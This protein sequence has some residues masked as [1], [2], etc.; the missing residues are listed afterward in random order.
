MAMLKVILY[1]HTFIFKGKQV[2]SDWLY[3]APPG[4]KMNVSQSGWIDQHVFDDQ[5][6]PNVMTNEEKKVLICDN[7]SSH[8]S[9]ST[10]RLCE[11]NKISI[12]LVPNSTHLLQPLDVAYFASLKTFWRQTL[13]DWRQTKDGKRCVALPK[14]VFSQLLKKTLALCENTSRQNLQKGFEST[15]MFPI[16]RET[17]L[18]KLPNYAKDVAEVSKQ[19]GVEFTR[20]LENIR[21]ADLNILPKPRKFLLPVIPGKSVS[22]EE[23]ANYYSNRQS[24]EASLRGK[25]RTRGGVRRNGRGGIKTLGRKTVTEIDNDVQ[26]NDQCLEELLDNNELQGIQ[27]EEIVVEYVSEDG[28]ITSVEKVQEEFIDTEFEENDFVLTVYEQE[29][30]PGQITEIKLENGEKMFKI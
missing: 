11:E 8:I 1:H 9:L 19:V 3:D 17:V 16:C 7:L 20:Y 4:T 27:S 6:L 12:C 2:W 18:K 15:G 28:K 24:A 29:L 23:V 21:N 10:L 22:V 25:A 14:A 30:F 26:N 13:F 5:F